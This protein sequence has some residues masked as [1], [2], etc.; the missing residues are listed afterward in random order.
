[1]HSPDVARDSDGKV[2]S[3]A[4]RIV[5]CLVEDHGVVNDGNVDT[6]GRTPMAV[7]CMAQNQTAIHELVHGRLAVR[8]PLG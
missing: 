7:A 1:M 2:L 5:R 6:A 4:N 3:P 8:A